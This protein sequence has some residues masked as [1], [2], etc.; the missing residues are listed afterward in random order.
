VFGWISR[1]WGT[2]AAPAPPEPIPMVVEDEDADL[3]LTPEELL[4]AE[5]ATEFWPFK[6]LSR[7]LQARYGTG[8]TA[9]DT[10]VMAAGV[11]EAWKARAVLARA[12]SHIGSTDTRAF[13]Q[14]INSHAAKASSGED[15]EKAAAAMTKAMEDE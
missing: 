10:S 15:Y 9:G 8:E 12:G 1:V 7:G 2:V 6:E 11:T 13:E 4:Q 3:Q 5:L 14:L